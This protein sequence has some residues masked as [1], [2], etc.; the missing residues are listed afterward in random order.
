MMAG[1]ENDSLAELL[2][3]GILL[4]SVL[5]VGNGEYRPHPAILG[6]LV[7]AGFLTKVTVYPLAAVA[8]AAI[9]LRAWQDHWLLNRTIRAAAWMLIPAALLGGLWWS[10]SIATYGWPD[11][12]GLRRHDSVVVGQIRTSEYIT[13]GYTADGKFVPSKG[14]NAWLNDGLVTTFD[15]FWGQFGWMGVPMPPNIYA[16][17]EIFSGIVILGA[18]LALIR[19][20]KAISIPQRDALLLLALAGL[21][22]VTEIVYYNLT[23]VQFQGRYLY[24]G[25]I[26]IAFFIAVGLAGWASLLANRVPAIRWLVPAV[27]LLFA[28]LDVYALFRIIGPQLG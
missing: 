5:T 24:P 18:G 9:L 15:S 21:L 13:T 7:G 27:M 6:L 17:L 14:F 28:V 2:A 20:R 25:L 11:F 4:A 19:F 26:S 16:L 23:F 8:L 3:G 22:A 1:V 12:L 10:H